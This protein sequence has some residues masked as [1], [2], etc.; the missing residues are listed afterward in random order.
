MILSDFFDKYYL[1]PSAENLD[2][3]LDFIFGYDF[4][5]Y[6]K[7]IDEAFRLYQ[8]ASRTEDL[9][10]MSSNGSVEWNTGYEFGPNA[11]HCITSVENYL[12]D[13][14][15]KTILILSP[16]PESKYVCRRSVEIENNTHREDICIQGEWFL[17]S[18]VKALTDLIERQH[19]EW[20]TLNLLGLPHVWLT[21]STNNQFREWVEENRKKI[22]FLVN[23]DWDFCGKDL[24]IPLRNQM[25]DWR[26]GLNFYTCGHGTFHFIPIFA[27]KN[28]K[29]YNLLNLGKCEF[30][31][32][33]DDE[34]QIGSEKTCECGRRYLEIEFHSHR[35]NKIIDSD[36]KLIDFGEL[37]NSL[38]CNY[39][40]LQ[41]HQSLDGLVSIYY[42]AECDSDDLDMILSFLYGRGLRRLVVKK[43]I[44]FK[45]GKKRYSAWRSESVQ[46]M[47]FFRKKRGI[48]Q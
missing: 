3:L 33:L 9:V 19:K 40:N 17:K 2:A 30:G 48:M 4:E 36:G 46:E 43:D 18:H 45:I 24:G 38:S 13:R 14:K 1:K 41:M 27:L 23:S 8:K 47:Q 11:K 35:Q 20:G 5:N 26:S 10:E 39:K 28:G 7:D 34:F 42:S 22:G 44:Y 32:G 31:N 29:S 15:T 12:R 21:L 37:Y 25:I 6:Q 16:V